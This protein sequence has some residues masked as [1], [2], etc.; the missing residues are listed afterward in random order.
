MLAPS[1]QSWTRQSRVD[2]MVMVAWLI[3]FADVGVTETR[4]AKYARDGGWSFVWIEARLS[5]ERT[6]SSRERSVRSASM[7]CCLTNFER[8]LNDSAST[9]MGRRARTNNSSMSKMSSQAF[10]P[11]RPSSRAKTVAI[12]RSEKDVSEKV[13]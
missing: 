1:E 5:V 9:S 10:A 6:M 4:R 13:C 11:S 2:M 3:C 8:I 12:S 7:V